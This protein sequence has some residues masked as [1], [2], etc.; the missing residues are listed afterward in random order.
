MYMSLILWGDEF[1]KGWTTW[2]LSAARIFFSLGE[3]TSV[4]V[5]GSATFAA[6]ASCF[7]FERALLFWN[8]LYT[9]VSD[10]WPC[11]PSSIVIS[12]IFCLLG[13]PFPSSKIRSRI[14]SCRGV[15]VQRCL[16]VILCPEHAINGS[17]YKLPSLSPDPKHHTILCQIADLKITTTVQ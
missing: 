15:G 6:G 12:L 13:V 10:I 1:S 4:S 11:C 2:T 5:S 14:W 16:A 3:S 7:L 9:F 17:Q 8:Q